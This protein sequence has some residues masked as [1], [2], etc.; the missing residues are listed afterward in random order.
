MVTPTCIYM[1]LTAPI[2]ID[3]EKKGL[4]QLGSRPGSI[5]TFQDLRFNQCHHLVAT[6]QKE[7]KLKK[8]VCT[9]RFPLYLISVLFQLHPYLKSSFAETFPP[10]LK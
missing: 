3:P 5:L 10:C 6:P 1:M 8:K 2:T 9:K 4:L 7:Q